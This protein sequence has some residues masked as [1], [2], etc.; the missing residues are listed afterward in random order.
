MADISELLKKIGEN[1]RKNGAFDDTV[2]TDVPILRRGS[3]IPQPKPREHTPD[4]FTELR[5]LPYRSD[6]RFEPVESIF[7]RQAKLME[8]YEDEYEYDGKLLVFE[9]SYS[10]LSGEQLRGY[11]TWRKY[12]RKGEIRPA[13]M[14]FIRLYASELINNIGVSG[15]AEAHEQ[16]V[17]LRDNWE[18]PSTQETINSWI[19]DHVV[20]YGLPPELLDS[21]PEIQGDK[22]METLMNCSQSSDSDLFTAL[23]ALSSYKLASSSFYRERPEDFT[24]AICAVWRALDAHYREHEGE[25]MLFTRLLG[26]RVKCGC[27]MFG[28]LIFCEQKRQP[29]REY[30]VNSIRR[31]ECSFGRWYLDTYHTSRGS[32]KMLGDLLRSAECIIREKLGAKY[33]L[34]GSTA[35]KTETA[36]IVKT[37]EKL[38][39]AKKRAQAEMIEI[40]VTKLGDIRKA[41]DITRDKLIV[42]DEPEPGADTPAPEPAPEPEPEQKTESG[43][44]SDLPLTA[45]EISYLRHLLYGSEAPAGIMPSLLA[46][47]INEKLFDI[48]DDTVLDMNGGDPLIIEDY[49]EELKGTI[50]E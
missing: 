50:P 8:N 31:Y 2:Y 3:E 24:E 44:V 13:H 18:R 37:L 20:Y 16:L 30:I 1:L 10:E 48:F 41:A 38:A 12:A 27:Y 9:P 28:A 26:R 25:T 6:M 14:T 4:K 32:N 43:Q 35:T 21:D 7:L 46:D 23:A 45:E 22:A 19:R 47:A 36:V 17:R 11:F 5:E 42:E 29:D 34:T 39:E 15:P 40:D 49:A 33:K